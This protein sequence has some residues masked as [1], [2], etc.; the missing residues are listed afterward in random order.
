MGIVSNL[1][2]GGAGYTGRGGPSAVSAAQVTNEG[3]ELQKPFIQDI[4][5][6]AQAETYDI[7]DDGTKTLRPYEE[8]TGPRIAGFST[9]QEDALS[10]LAQLGRS[11]LAGTELAS[12]TPYFQSARDATGLSALPFTAAAAEQLMNPYLDQVVDIQ[13]REAQRRFDSQVVPKLDAE[14][15]AAGSFGGS[16]AAILQAEANRN[17][18]QQLD[19]IRAKGMLTAYEQA[20]KA[21]EQQKA[22]ESEAARMYTALGTEAPSQAARELGLLSSAGEARQSQEQRAL[23]LAEAEFIRQRDF[24]MRQLQEYQSLVRGFPFSPSTYEVKPE[25]KAQ[26]TFGQQLIG[27]LGTAAGLYGAF[28]GFQ[29][30]RQAGGQVVPRQS[31]GQVRGGLAGLERHQDN[32][33]SQAELERRAR[34]KGTPLSHMIMPFLRNDKGLLS[35]AQQRM[36]Q[37]PPIRDDQNLAKIISEAGRTVVPSVAA[38]LRAG[39]P[40]VADAVGSI[41][42]SRETIS[43]TVG[44]LIET[45]TPSGERLEAF[46]KQKQE[47]IADGRIK[48]GTFPR[49]GERLAR[50]IGDTRYNILGKETDSMSS[51]EGDFGSFEEA[52]QA[53]KFI[54]ERKGAQDKRQAALAKIEGK[55]D[56]EVMYEDTITESDDTEISKTE[57]GT[58]V[59]PNMNIPDLELMYENTDTIITERLEPQ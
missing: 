15:V 8:F 48:T 18:Q 47:A 5:E 24:P 17:L 59:E 39:I 42:P 10:G 32:Y 25:Y 6:T 12:S 49:E 4:F 43:D 33:I 16:R 57:S 22:R 46:Q 35:Q 51:T 54:E 34:Q 28:G 44:N 13:Q 9:E 52:E 36:G 14:A 37:T 11:G 29:P 7:A 50:K 58:T 31:G 20:Q 53:S 27:G 2:G 19:D 3:F 38:P 1:F 45:I 21:F 30:G 55:P 41:V 40:P 56:L 23:D 26:P